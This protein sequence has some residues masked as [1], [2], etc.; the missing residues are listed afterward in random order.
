MMIQAIREKLQEVVETAAQVDANLEKIEEAESR[1]A[2]PQAPLFLAQALLDAE[3]AR[4]QLDVLLT[5][6]GCHL[7][8][9]EEE[10]EEAGKYLP[11][12]E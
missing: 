10:G 11:R 12:A 4:F 9:E 7:P 1:G 3:K 2:E 6:T 8:R 5:Q